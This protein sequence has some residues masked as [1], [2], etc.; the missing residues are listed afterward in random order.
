LEN[1]NEKP[2]NQIKELKLAESGRINEEINVINDIK[3]SIMNF[4]LR[5][6]R[7]IMVLPMEELRIQKFKQILN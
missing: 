2:D 4:I 3:N 7:D 5:D 6:L 1:E